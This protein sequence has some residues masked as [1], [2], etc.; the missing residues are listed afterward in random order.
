MTGQW[1]RSSQRYK[2]SE[3]NSLRKVN[4]LTEHVESMTRNGDTYEISN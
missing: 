1:C 2:T 3:K 4:L